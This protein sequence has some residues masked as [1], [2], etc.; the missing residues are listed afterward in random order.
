M[1]AIVNAD[2][3]LVSVGSVVADPLPEG[4]T[5]HR[6]TPEDA[7]LLAAGGRW[8][9]G[10]VIPAPEP[11]LTPTI[12]ERLAAV[13]RAVAGDPEAFKEVAARV[14]NMPSVDEV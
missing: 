9:N 11:D 1:F 14:A 5:A 12:E 4:L 2:G 7:A 13:E 3:V 10:G 8:E 6:L